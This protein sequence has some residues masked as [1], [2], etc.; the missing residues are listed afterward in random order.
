MV[1]TKFVG[2][3]DEGTSSVRFI[4]FRAG[5]NEIVSFHQIEIPSE[6]PQEGWVEQDPVLIYDMVKRCIEEC[7][8]KFIN[9]GHQTK[10][11]KKKVKIKLWIFDFCNPYFVQMYS[12]L[13]LLLLKIFILN[14]SNYELL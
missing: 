8:Q 14:L 2:A 9:Q 3:I 7:V 12:H 6:Y 10:V 11:S 4:I 13:S 5:T 1:S